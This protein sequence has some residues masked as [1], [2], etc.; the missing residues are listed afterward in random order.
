MP[1]DASAQELQSAWAALG[2]TSEPPATE[3]DLHKRIEDGLPARFFDVFRRALKDIPDRTWAEILAI[4][5]SQIKRIRGSDEPLKT[6]VGS[7][8]VTFAL[9]MVRAEDVLGG[10]DAALT[11]F[12]TG[13]MALGGRKPVEM[14]DTYIGA[15][16]VDR[17]LRQMDYEVYI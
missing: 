17:A 7:H 14:L 2:A 5:V 1:F 12:Q 11:W 6:D 9:L 16:L 4:S 8:L 13:Q 10:R 15:A 3:I